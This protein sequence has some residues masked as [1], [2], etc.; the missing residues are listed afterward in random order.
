LSQARSFLALDLGAESGRAVV[1]KLR[2]NVLDLEV[3]HR[4]PNIPVRVPDGLH[5]DVLRLFQEMK[6]GLRLASRE[7]QLASLGLDTWG[8]DFALLDSAGALLANPHHYRDS[9]TDGK[10]EEVFAVVPREEIFR[11]TGI[12]FMQLNTLYQMYALKQ[13]SPHLLD[14]AAKIV[15]IPDLFNYWFSGEAV[16]EFTEATTSQM[17]DPVR[18]RWAS[19]LADRLGLPL[20][21]M[22]PVVQPGSRLGEI[23]PF[24]AE[25]CECPPVPVIAPACHDT[26]SA[27]A[28]VPAEG[29]DF[30]YIS[31]GTWSLVGVEVDQPVIT[32]R[33]LQYNFTNEG[34]VAGTYRLLKNVMGLWL[35]QECR[36]TWERRGV[37][38]DYTRLTEMAAEAPAFRSILDPDDPAF[39]HPGDMPARIQEFCRSTSQPVPEDPG[40]IVRTALD[41]LALK[42]RWVVERLEELTGRSLPVI[43]VVGGGTQNRLLT[44]L[45]ADASRRQV[46]AGPV[47][48]TAMGNILMQAIGLGEIGSVAEGRSIVRS[49]VDLATYEPRPDAAAMADEAYERFL[50]LGPR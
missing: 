22:A 39:L 48:A 7:N 18:G 50:R 44:Q 40:S 17:F 8:V 11:T 14:A 42:Y 1:G 28:A 2:G 19:E 31:S 30:V 37:S 36:R 34:G 12:Q 38:Y 4:F 9:R 24:V 33:S 41:S 26:G 47:E 3:V 20:D 29:R 13:S 21:K 43:H 49:S 45:T 32:E 6:E 23:L 27:V 35:V 16:C 25:E 5:W 10:M 46:I 15:M